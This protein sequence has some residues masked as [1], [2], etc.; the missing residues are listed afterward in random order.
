M[1]AIIAEAP[2]RVV[3]TKPAT[4]DLSPATDRCDR[5]G[6]EAF[7]RVTFPGDSELLMCGHDFAQHEQKLLVA[8]TAISDQRAF[9]GELS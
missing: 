8:A 2:T 5:C 4:R 3:V 7:V 9:I 1:T 6:A